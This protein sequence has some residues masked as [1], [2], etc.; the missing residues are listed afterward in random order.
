MSDDRSDPPRLD[1]YEPTVRFDGGNM[2]CGN[3]LLLQIRRRIDP[4]STGQLLEVR[5]TEPSVAEDLP[6][7]C[8]LT[9]NELVTQQH[10]R[11]HG[12]WSF[13]IAKNR[14]SPVSTQVGAAEPPGPAAPAREAARSGAPQARSGVRDG[15]AARHAI[16]PFSVM[17]IGSWPRPDWLLQA[18][19]DRL[20]GRLA[21]SEFTALAD[22]AVSQVVEAQLEAG[23]DVVTDGEQRR[24]SYA[25]FVGARLD[26]C[27]LIPIVDLLPYV[28]HPDEFARE[29]RALDVPAESV[30]H[31]AVF[32]K[33]ARNAARP[34][35]TH[36]LRA[37]Q[38]LTDRPVKIATS[39]PLLAHPHDVAGVRLGSG[40]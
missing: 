22:R 33:L 9:G 25:S 19:H 37:V 30:R 15:G 36:E 2:D 34:L 27:Q 7:W 23:V 5:S 21:D 31:P 20:E 14:F 38:S 6:S 10:D 3:G 24:D 8:R 26:N 4:L 28:E 11:E 40:L 18:L 35:A 16:A 17:G 32:G 12:S 13:L 39:G 29:L 1:P